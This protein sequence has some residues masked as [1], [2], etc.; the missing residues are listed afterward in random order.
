MNNLQPKTTDWV[1]GVQWKAGEHGMN[2]TAGVTIDYTKVPIDADGKRIVKVATA[3]CKDTTTGKYVPYQSTKVTETFDGDGT[4]TTFTLTTEV[5]PEDN[6]K[7]TVDSIEKKEGVDFIIKRTAS[8]GKYVTSVELATAPATGVG[9]VEVTIT[10]V[11]INPRLTNDTV[12]CTDGDGVVGDLIHGKVYE[13]ACNG[14][15][16]FFKKHTPMIEY[17]KANYNGIS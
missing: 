16:E 2:G 5:H 4:T 9:N 7:V 10:P 6:I 13:A 15:D 8:S 1:T 12:D 11:P 3:I 17:I 14:V